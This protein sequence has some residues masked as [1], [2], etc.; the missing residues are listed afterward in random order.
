MLS[1]VKGADGAWPDLAATGSLAQP[2]DTHGPVLGGWG[3]MFAK[4]SSRGSRLFPEI[5]I[6][7][8]T[9]NRSSLI[10]L[11]PQAQLAGAIVAVGV[12]AAICFLA[13]GRI[14]YER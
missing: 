12:V 1:G 11:A 5:C 3:N 8:R 7:L 14:G 4:I 6:N 13:V 10:R 9:R 2:W